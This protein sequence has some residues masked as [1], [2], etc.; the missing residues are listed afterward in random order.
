MHSM[1]RVAT[2]G[3]EGEEE[4]EWNNCQEVTVTNTSV[5]EDVAE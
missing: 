5:L 4:E 2:A 3:A 1:Q